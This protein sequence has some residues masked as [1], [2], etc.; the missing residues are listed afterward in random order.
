MGIYVKLRVGDINRSA[1]HFDG[2]KLITAPHRSLRLTR[3][4]D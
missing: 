4:D 3:Q 1:V 2:K